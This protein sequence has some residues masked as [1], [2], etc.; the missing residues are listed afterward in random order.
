[1][2]DP[3]KENQLNKSMEDLSKNDMEDL[4]KNNQLGKE[5]KKESIYFP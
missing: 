2:E 3:C 5:V 4:G 1:V